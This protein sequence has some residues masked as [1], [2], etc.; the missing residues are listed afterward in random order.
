MGHKWVKIDRV[1]IGSPEDVPLLPLA[2]A[3]VAKYE[4][5]PEHLINHRLPP[6]ISDQKYNQYLKEVASLCGIDKNIPTHT[7][8][9]TFATAITVENGIPIETVS[10]MLAH[11]SIRVIQ[12]HAP[13]TRKKVSENMQVLRQKLFFPRKAKSTKTGCQSD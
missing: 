4:D 9:Y 1:K 5:H 13:I 3:L 8:R 7:G 11:K 2:E 10:R 6:V 12:I